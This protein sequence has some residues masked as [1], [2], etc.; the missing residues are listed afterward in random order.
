MDEEALNPNFTHLWE[1]IDTD[2]WVLLQGSTRSGKTWSIIQF[3]ISFCYRYENAG[4]EIDIVRDT[5]TSLKATILKDFM[6]VL[7]ENGLYSE[8]DHHRTDHVYKLFGNTISYYGADEPKKIHGRARDILIINEANHIEEETIDQLAPRTR[9]RIICDFN[10]ALGDEHWLDKYMVDY[11]PLITT[12]KD[13]PYLTREQVEDIE[14]RRDNKYWWS[15]YGEGKRAKVQGAVFER[16]SVGKFPDTKDYWFGM[17]FGFSND[18]TALV[19]TFIDKKE[20]KIYAQELVYSTH[21]KTGEISE[22]C[23]N[24]CGKSLII[25]DSAE[26]RLISELR[27]KKI[28]IQGAVKVSINEGVTLMNDYEIVITE[29]SVNLRKELSKYRWADKGKTVPIDDYNHAIDALR[30]AC[31]FKLS[32]PSYGRYSIG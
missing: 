31:M 26:P 10:P 15:I 30:Y 17:D 14:S 8:S 32:N 1:K 3:I 19:K 22:L 20:K 2:R 4:I 7:S 21:L 16:W 24:H 5:F 25:A 23:E 13:N 9:Y 27:S 11:P 6:Q 12:Y 28:N 29:D 18:P